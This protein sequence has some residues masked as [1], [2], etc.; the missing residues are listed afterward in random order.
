MARRVLVL[1]SQGVLGTFIAREFSAAGWQVTRAGRRPEGAADFRL[2]DFDERTDLRQACAEVNLVVNTAH[3]HELA[4]ERTVLR[5]GGTLINL[6]DFTQAEHAQLASEGVEGQ[7]SVVAHTG[8]SGIAYLAIAEMLREHR[9]AD[10]AEYSLMF[11]ASGSSGRAGA[12]FAHSL[13][14][15]SS[16]HET[17]IVPFPE[18]FGKRRCLEVGANGNAVLRKGIGD[19]PL[20]H[21]LCMQPRALQRML[22][23]LNSVRVIGLMP[24]VSFTAGARKVPSAPSDEPICEWIAISRG[25]TRLA[26]QTLAGKGYYRMTAAATVAFGEALLGPNVSASG[27]PGLRSIDELITLAD[28]RPAIEKHGI[29]IHSQRVDT[30]ATGA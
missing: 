4:P 5:H 15:G 3:H 16:H 8:F 21:Y 28:V 14:T 17:T 30:V 20:R 24:K 6:T 1:G 7:G 12:L 10:A 26:A 29:T 2:I 13:L 23:G 22:L 11:A 19:V 9:E 27:K 18:P 25:G